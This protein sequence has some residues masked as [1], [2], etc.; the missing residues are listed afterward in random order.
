MNALLFVV[1]VV[2]IGVWAYAVATYYTNHS[3]PPTSAC[4]GNCRQGRDCT[5]GIDQEKLRLED[6]FNSS[7]WPFPKSKP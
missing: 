4:T 5:C 1:V 7:N 3:N 2:A 6:E